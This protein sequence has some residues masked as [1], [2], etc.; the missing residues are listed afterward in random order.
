MNEGV[1]TVNLAGVIVAFNQAA[2]KILSKKQD[3]VLRRKYLEVFFEWEE[4]DDFNQ[5]IF[6]AVYESSVKHNRVVNY[7][8]GH[9]TKTLFMTTSFLTDERSGVIEKIGVIAVFTDIT[10]LQELRDAVQ[11]MEHIKKLNEQLEIRNQFISQAFGRYVSDQ[12]VRS[13]LEDPSSLRL[14][15]EKK[16]LSVMMTDLRGFTA[17]S[18]NLP[19]EAVVSII[20]HY[21]GVMVDVI[22]KY[23]GT[24]LEFIGDAIMVVFGAPVWQQD[25]AAKALACAV[26]MQLAMESVNQWNRKQGFP[27]IAMGIGLNTGQVVVG[28][29]GSE[30][31]TKYGL[32]GRHVNLASRMES[33]T[34][35]GQ[36]FVAEETL[37][38]ANVPVE[39]GD[40]LTVQPKG[41]PHPITIYDV[42]GVGEPYHLRLPQEVEVFKPFIK[43]VHFQIRK[44][45]NKQ[46]SQEAWSGQAVALS[47]CSVMI[48]STAPLAVMDN[49]ELLLI[50]AEELK[51]DEIYG[52]VQTVTNNGEFKVRFTHLSPKMNLYLKSEKA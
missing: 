47:D 31:R 52:K 35:G 11:A 9:T 34:V 23:G 21:L 28:N 33:F 46:V 27:E 17:L 40:T 14:G 25:H 32:V 48:A 30:K 22:F 29:I 41:I 24:I 7:Y 15:G 19:P 37:S 51:Q 6:D 18:E 10:E 49:L 16:Y 12:I 45:E 44:V 4:N 3:E 26:D 8:N 5:L 42:I 39:I 20:N 1:L 2:E 43:S 13:L 50:E 36:I 38:A